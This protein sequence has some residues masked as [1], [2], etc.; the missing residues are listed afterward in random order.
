MD[1][2]E[3]CVPFTTPLSIIV[4]GASQSGKTVWIAKLLKN[5]R[6]MF[7]DEIVEIMFVYSVWQDIYEQMEKEIPGIKF[8]NHI[9]SKEEIEEFTADSAHRLMVLDDQMS[10]MS[11]CKHFVEIFTVFCHHRKLSTVLVLQNIFTNAPC[12]RDI[13][14]NVQAICLFKNMRCSQQVRCLANQMFPGRHKYF[15]EAY[16]KACSQ[17]FSCLIVDL[18]PRTDVKLQLRSCVLPGQGPTIVYLPKT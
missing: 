7:T 11:T 6:E 13:T 14:L 8:I 1:A 3:S 2:T 16:E 10:N 15:L 5:K 4:S 17:P 9:P 18:N 12:L